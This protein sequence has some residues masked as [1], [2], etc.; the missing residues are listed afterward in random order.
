MRL[1]VVIILGLIFFNV[2]LIIFGGYF[3]IEDETPLGAKNL[4][5]DA[6]YNKYSNLQEGTFETILITSGGIFIGVVG[7]GALLK[8]S[9][10][11]GQFLGAGMI[12]SI[13]AGLWAGLSAPFT[14]MGQYWGW[15]GDLIYSAIIMAIGIITVIGIA[16]IFT[17]KGDVY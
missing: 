3:D 8:G 7:I 11:T 14:Q 13:I 5:S 15:Q 12:I 16:E 2:S 9:I 17:N 1:I 6:D 10:P 4:T